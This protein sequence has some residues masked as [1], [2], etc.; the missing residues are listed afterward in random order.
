MITTRTNNFR[1]NYTDYFPGEKI[2][3][4]KTVCSSRISSTNIDIRTVTILQPLPQQYPHMK[5]SIKL[6]YQPIKSIKFWLAVTSPLF[7]FI[8]PS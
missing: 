1:F 3:Q 4:R 7:V 8:L 6:R 2:W 5:T